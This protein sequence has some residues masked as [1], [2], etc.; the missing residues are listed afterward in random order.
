MFPSLMLPADKTEKNVS[1]EILFSQQSVV[2]C[3]LYHRIDDRPILILLG[4]GHR[5]TRGGKEEGS[6]LSGEKT[7]CY[8]ITE[9]LN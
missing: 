9:R 7:L 2:A 3:D 8:E 4:L 5:I 6:P 1:V